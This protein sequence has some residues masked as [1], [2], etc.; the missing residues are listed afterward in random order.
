MKNKLFF[1]VFIYLLFQNIQAQTVSHGY[2]IVDGVKYANSSG[3]V[4]WSDEIAV[5]NSSIAS[6]QIYFKKVP[7]TS[8]KYKVQEHLTFTSDGTEN[9]VSVVLYIFDSDQYWSV[10]PNKGSVQ[11][12]VKNNQTT[13]IIKNVKTCVNGTQRC[14]TV[15]GQIVLGN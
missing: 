3:Q 6:F 11:V 13:I 2:Y 15:S 8:G 14:K 1:S 12:K 7:S 9:E 10:A 5:M 4:I